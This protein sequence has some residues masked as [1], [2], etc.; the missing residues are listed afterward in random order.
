ME[1][2]NRIS[3]KFAGMDGWDRA[4]F[5][6][7]EGRQYYKS[8]ELMPH[9]NFIR[10]SKADQEKLLNSLHSTDE[11]DG[12]PGWPVPRERFELVE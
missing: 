1:D 3:I 9:P 5:I 10:L 8:V 12:E 11:F 6:L 4:V 7:R 2:T